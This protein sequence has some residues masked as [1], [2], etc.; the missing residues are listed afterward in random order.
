MARLDSVCA[1]KREHDI[2]ISIR[3]PIILINSNCRAFFEGC[4]ASQIQ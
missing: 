2:F 3:I 1:D 4:Y